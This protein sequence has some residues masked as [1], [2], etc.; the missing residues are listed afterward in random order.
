MTVP[1]DG[2]FSDIEVLML[3]NHYCVSS[4]DLLVKMLQKCPN[5]TV[6]GLTPSNCSCQEVGGISFLSDSICNIRYP[7]NWLY[8]VDEETRCIDTDETRE[9]TLPLDVKIPLTYDLAQSLYDDR[10]TR[11]V[12]LDYA[13]DYLNTNEEK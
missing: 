5:V 3:V 12:L 7:V 2:R 13:L 6:M 11:D 1:A 4:G 9:C 8:E 10:K